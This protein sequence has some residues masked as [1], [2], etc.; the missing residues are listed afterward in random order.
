MF[1]LYVCVFCLAVLLFCVFPFC[2]AFVLFCLAC[3]SPCC[4]C[5]CLLCVY[6]LVCSVSSVVSVAW[7]V[8]AGCSVCVLCLFY[9]VSVYY[10]FSVC[11]LLCV[12]AVC[13]LY[14]WRV[15]VIGLCVCA[16]VC[17]LCL[18]VLCIICVCSL[19]LLYM[20]V[21]CVCVPLCVMCPLYSVCVYFPVCMYMCLLCICV[22]V[23]P[24]SLVYVSVL[25]SCSVFVLL[26]T[27]LVWRL[28][29]WCDGRLFLGLVVL[30]FGGCGVCE[31]FLFFYSGFLVGGR[32][33]LGFCYRTFF[34]GCSW[35]LRHTR[36]FFKDIT[37]SYY[38]CEM[39]VIGLYMCLLAHLCHTPHCSDIAPVYTCAPCLPLPVFVSI[40]AWCYP[41]VSFRVA[42]ILCLPY[43][44]SCVCLCL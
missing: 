21:Y 22:S 29:W 20:C 31:F 18:C 43:T 37:H 36:N 44:L 10:P 17:L 33:L 38:C 42:L 2:L 13:V 16:C 8:S 39:P 28:S 5:V 12:S 32:L 26:V 15:S 3:C 9:C 25:C 1:S 35:G 19:C 30:V 24:I 23:F 6:C 41:R 11:V 4:S 40:C 14:V 34:C 7:S 27:L